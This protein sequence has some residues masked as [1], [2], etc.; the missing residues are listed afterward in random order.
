LK[1]WADKYIIGLTGSI[2]TGKSV[3]RRMLEHLGAYGIDADALA[4]RAMAPGAPGYKEV[5]ETFGKFILQPDGQVDR[6]KLGRLVFADADA[7]AKQE[8]IIHPLV[9]QALDMLIKRA[10]Q[11]VIVI[12]AIKLVEARINNDCDSLWVVYAPPEVQL[13]RLVE[14]RKMSEGDARLRIASQI[15]QEIHMSAANVVIKNETSFEDTWKQVTQAWMRSVPAGEV[16]Y[17][18]ESQPVRLPLGEAT[19]RRAGPRQVDEIVQVLNSTHKGQPALSHNDVMAQLGEKAFLLLCIEQKTMGIISWQ[20]ENLVARST[21]ITLDP[22]LSPAQYL[23]IM[24]REMERASTDLQCEASLIFV[25]PHLAKHD[26]L[27]KSLGYEPKDPVTLGVLAWQEAA[28]ESMPA[29]SVLYFKQ[30]RQD[31]VLR[32]I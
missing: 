22:L 4:H 19:V 16:K 17:V 9:S 21:D 6:A 28:E 13:K 7:L 8:A 26:A 32:P 11:K 15:P 3:V 20:V 18:P 10:S 31:R 23:P 5:V 25:P 30:L 24:I 14:Q 29:G 2:G 27:W 1:K 12:E